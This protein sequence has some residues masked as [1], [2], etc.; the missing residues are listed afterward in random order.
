M[1]DDDLEQRIRTVLRADAENARVSPHA[2]TRVSARLTDA[3]PRSHRGRSIGLAVAGVAALATVGAIVGPQ[4]LRSNEPEGGHMPV[5]GG[6][7]TVLSAETPGPVRNSPYPGP[8]SGTG[9]IGKIRVGYEVDIRLI[10]SPGDDGTTRVE[11]AAYSIT[12]HPVGRPPYAR[13][14]IATVADPTDKVGVCQLRVVNGHTK[15]VI[16]SVAPAGEACGKPV[17]YAI[18]DTKFTKTG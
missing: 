15:T 11:L 5:A 9:T 18:G 10:Q 7:P 16:V 17:T 1:S 12:P 13:A 14:E 6:S 2:W 4:L 3:R 8:Q